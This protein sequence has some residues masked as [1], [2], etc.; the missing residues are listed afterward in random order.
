MSQGKP[1]PPCM[2]SCPKRQVG[3]RSTCR[4]WKEYERARDA[5]YNKAYR[6]T[7]LRLPARVSKGWAKFRE[8]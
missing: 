2:A 5:Y 3:C 4:P 6:E 8:V 1:I 7:I